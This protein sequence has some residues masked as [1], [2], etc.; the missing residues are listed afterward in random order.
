MKSGWK[1]YKKSSV[2]RP[3]LGLAL[4]Y[5]TVLSMGPI[6]SAYCF[7]RGMSEA[8]LG[9][10][11]AVGAIFGILSTVAFPHLRERLGLVKTGLMSI[12][13][14]IATIALCLVSA[15]Y[16]YPED[17]NCSAFKA[18]GAEEELV[19]CKARY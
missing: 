5:A 12:W 14:M 9:S 6:M 16:S 2:F 1:V 18:D 4:L 11:R 8:L 3:G 15:E 10:L 17:G 7:Y 13:G 19:S